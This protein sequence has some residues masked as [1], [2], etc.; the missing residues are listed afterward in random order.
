MLPRNHDYSGQGYRKQ[1]TQNPKLYTNGRGALSI[2]LLGNTIP[3]KDQLRGE[4]GGSDQKL[5]TIMVG[6]PP[7]RI[8]GE[9]EKN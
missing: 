7:Q 2:T 1:K 5:N 9:L 8:W 3:K 4:A 6:T